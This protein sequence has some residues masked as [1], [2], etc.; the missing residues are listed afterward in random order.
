MDHQKIGLEREPLQWGSRFSVGIKELDM[1]HQGLIRLINRLILVSE[2]HSIHSDIIKSALEEMTAYAQVHFK[3]EERLMEAYDFPL[4]KEH[5]KSHLDFQVKTMD[6]Y[7][8]K[9]QSAEQIAEDLSNYLGNW[10]THHI[11]QEDM[12]Y[13]AFFS[14]KGLR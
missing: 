11:L 14:D 5:K 2:T 6:L 3:A 12:A 10:L 4:M 13:K 7:E 9:G 8:G 1:Q